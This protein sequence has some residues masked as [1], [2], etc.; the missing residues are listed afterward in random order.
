MTQNFFFDVA[1]ANKLTGSYY[2][3]SYSISAISSMLRS[4]VALNLIIIGRCYFKLILCALCT[5][6]FVL[7]FVVVLLSLCY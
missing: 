5:P 2:K 6:S 4:I 3:C 1:I 7:F